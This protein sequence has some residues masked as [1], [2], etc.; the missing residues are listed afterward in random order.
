MKQLIA[1]NL[2]ELQ[3]LLVTFNKG[4]LFRGQIQHYGEPDY[5]SVISSFDRTICIQSETVKW[6]CY[7]SR[8]LEGLIGNHVNDLAFV[9]ALLQ[10]Y[11]WRSFYIDCSSSPAVSAWFASHKYT[12]SLGID[13]C[14]DC[15]ENFLLERKK[16]ARY[17]FEEGE[18]H[19][20][21]ID[22]SIAEKIGL[23]DLSSLAI[24]GFYPRTEAQKAWL[25]GPTH[26]KR[27]PRECFVAH[28]TASRSLFREYAR[29]HQ[30]HDTDS[31]FP[32][33][34]RDPI[35]KELLE[36][37]WREIESIRDPNF[38]V[39]VF[40]RSLE[41]PEYQ[42]SFEKIASPETAFYKGGKIGEMFG[43][44]DT[45]KGKL[46]GGTVQSAS[47]I[48]IF[49]SANSDTPL[50]FP[51]IEERLQGKSYFAFEIDEI[52]KHPSMGYN[53]QYQKG[54]GVITHA[55]DLFEV[56]ELVVLHPGQKMTNVSFT[57]GWFYRK[58]NCGL[59]EREHNENECS[60]GNEEIHKRHISALVIAENL[61]SD[62]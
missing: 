5:P 39:P 42:K 30:L 58:K 31:L 3:E 22:K 24:E 28:I 13:M 52:V 51:K 47:S 60:C 37:P 33:A 61:L 16:F 18:G 43:A 55:P 14:E 21:V 11:G 10:Q 57:P 32:P 4:M 17:D 15:G 36:L 23:I 27:L 20:Y 40:K 53:T 25:I 26:G 29:L 9:Q 34:V 19:L 59:W 2:N 48:I 62:R 7:A 38:P 44:I 35:L 54:V 56:S 8:V 12:E 6:M 50:S 45:T 46:T 41:L 49:G 1:N